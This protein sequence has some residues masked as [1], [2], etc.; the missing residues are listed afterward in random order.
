MRK[1]MPWQH[2]SLVD[3][4]HGVVLENFKWICVCSPS[5]TNTLPH[6]LCVWVCVAVVVMGGRLKL[7]LMTV[8]LR[9]EST[10]IYIKCFEQPQDSVSIMFSIRCC[11]IHILSDPCVVSFGIGQLKLN[12]Y[13]Y[14]SWH[15]TPSLRIPLLSFDSEKSLRSWRVVTCPQGGYIVL[16]QHCLYTPFFYPSLI[17]VLLKLNSESLL[18]LFVISSITMRP[19]IVSDSLRC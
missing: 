14:C 7:G 8:W 16:Y 11:S 13:T 19:A 18:K 5:S 10:D 6:A 17:V 15:L 2:V 4:T 3:K 12:L 1:D 9:L